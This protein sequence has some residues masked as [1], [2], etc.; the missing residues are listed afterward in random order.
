[1]PTKQYR[2]FLKLYST[3]ILSLAYTAGA[4][5]SRRKQFVKLALALALANDRLPEKENTYHAR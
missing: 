1:M 4:C 3:A 2:H 5:F